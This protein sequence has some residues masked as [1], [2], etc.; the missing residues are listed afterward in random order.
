MNEETFRRGKEV[1]A[2]QNLHDVARQVTLSPTRVFIRCSIGHS[3]K[4]GLSLGLESWS[5]PLESWSGIKRLKL[6]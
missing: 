4:C 3:I 1:A 6:H 5:G 2:Q